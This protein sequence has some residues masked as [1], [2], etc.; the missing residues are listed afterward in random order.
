MTNKL[1]I[2]QILEQARK[3][4]GLTQEDLAKRAGTSRITVGRVEAGFDPKLSTIYEM[5]RAMGLEL[6]L[7]PKALAAEVQAFL[8][9]GGRTLG[10]PQGASAPPSVVELAGKATALATATVTVPATPAKSPTAA[11]T[12]G[13]PRRGLVPLQASVQA[14]WAP[15]RAV[16]T[17]PS[18]PPPPPQPPAGKQ[19]AATAGSRLTITGSAAKVLGIPATRSKKAPE[20]R[21]KP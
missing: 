17:K 13:K 10:Q 14:P 6:T 12:P 19:H 9:S 11:A 8:R 16:D 15:T 4:Q 3:T 20:G 7:V 21:E 2:V 18:P 5:A 1:N